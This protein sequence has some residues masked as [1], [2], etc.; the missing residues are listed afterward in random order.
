[1][2]HDT[3]GTRH[4]HGEIFSKYY[5]IKLKSDCIYHSPIDL[6]QQADIVRLLF[7]KLIGAW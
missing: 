6:G 4:A 2:S 5:Q 7:Q 3:K 1:M